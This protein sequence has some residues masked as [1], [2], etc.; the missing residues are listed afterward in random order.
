[1]RAGRCEPLLGGVFIW[2]GFSGMQ[3]GP[4]P[5]ESPVEVGGQSNTQE[6][7][8]SRLPLHPASQ[9]DETWYHCV[10]WLALG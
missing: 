2:A 8:G 5:G 1:M 4:G 10:R 6:A 7:Q 3:S 9:R